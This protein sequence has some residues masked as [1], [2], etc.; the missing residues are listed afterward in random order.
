VIYFCGCLFLGSSENKIIFKITD[1]IP[2]AYLRKIVPMASTKI[3]FYIY[4]LLIISPGIHATKMPSP[5]IHCIIFNMMK[6]AI[7]WQKQKQKQVIHL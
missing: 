2:G 3:A 5:K 6:E 1:S 4:Y 7:T